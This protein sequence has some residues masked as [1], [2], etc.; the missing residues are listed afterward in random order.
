MRQTGVAA[1]DDQDQ[2]S[3]ASATYDVLVSLV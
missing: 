3:E 2:G 1:H